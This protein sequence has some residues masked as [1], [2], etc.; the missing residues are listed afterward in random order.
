MLHSTEKIPAPSAFLTHLDEGTYLI[1]RDIEAG[2]Y[3]GQG[4]SCYWA[5]LR[6]V[7]GGTR[8]IIANNI[9]D[10][11]FFVQIAPTDFAFTI[12]RCPVDLAKK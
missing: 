10:G 9:S 11:N 7:S 2:L 6:N 1:G 12:K 4:D 5:R 3:Q 8:S